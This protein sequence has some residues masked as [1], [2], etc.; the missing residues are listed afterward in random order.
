MCFKTQVGLLLSIAMS[1]YFHSAKADASFYGVYWGQGV[2]HNLLELPEEFV[3]SN[4]RYE[5]SYLV[6]LSYKQSCGDV[7]FLNSWGVKGFCEL[8]GVKHFG[9]QNNYEVDLAYQ[10]VSPSLRIRQ[11]DIR[12]GAAMGLSYALGEPSYEDGPKAN[13]EKR[14]RFQNFNSYELIFSP[15]GETYSVFSRIHHRSGVY[16]LV[17]PQNVG[18]NFV[19]LGVLVEL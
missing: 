11:V 17:A 1:L 10:L 13:P 4:V 5:P 6:A 14:Y 15:V 19:S 12:F 7:A 18:S 3:A 16:G 8:I 2:D 9:L